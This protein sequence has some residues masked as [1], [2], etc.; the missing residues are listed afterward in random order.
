[1]ARE[2][3]IDDYLLVCVNVFD[4]HTRLVVSVLFVSRR[5]H[6]VLFHFY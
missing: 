1:V 2:L 3:S 5:F 4:A 6:F